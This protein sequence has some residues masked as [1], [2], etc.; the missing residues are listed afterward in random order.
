MKPA[1]SLTAALG[2][3]VSAP[4]VISL[5]GGGGKTT[6]MFRLAH[7][8]KALGKKV[9]VTTTTNIG[10][11]EPGECDIVMIEGFRDF[12]QLA[13]LPAAS[14]TCLGSGLIEGEILKV[15]SIAPETIDRLQAERIFDCILVEADGA[16]RKPIKA[17]ADYEPIIPAAATLTIGVIGLDAVG[18]AVSEDNIHRCELF[19]AC[20]GKK[21]GELVDRESIIRL[22]LSEKGLFKNAPAGCRKIV[23]LNKADTKDLVHAGQE[24][25]RGLTGS[26]VKG[27]IVAS[28]QQS[29]YKVVLRPW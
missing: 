27:C 5:V 11:P 18:K 12:Q 22:I 3:A 28:L 26:G 2:I 21:S 14:I 24:I 23:L 19:C 16:K 25:A 17:P 13:D 9:L 20:T 6:A 10:V 8:M 15:K 29:S 4:C 7:E 1:V